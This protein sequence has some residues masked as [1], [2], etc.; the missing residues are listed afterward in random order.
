MLLKWKRQTTLYIVCFSIPFI[1]SNKGCRSFYIT[2]KNMSRVILYLVPGVIGPIQK[3]LY[4]LTT[5]IYCLH[6]KI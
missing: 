4:Q 5:F 3:K 6:E 2:Y 1:I